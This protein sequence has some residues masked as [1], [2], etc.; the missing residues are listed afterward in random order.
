LRKKSVLV[1]QKQQRIK[2]VNYT[3]RA[4]RKLKPELW[5][6]VKPVGGQAAIQG[7]PFNLHRLIQ[8]GKAANPNQT[9]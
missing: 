6:A 8:S 9:R 7:L 4:R 3:R 1:L 2:S 5:P